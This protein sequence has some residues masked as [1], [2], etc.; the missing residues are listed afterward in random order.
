MESSSTVRSPAGRV[1]LKNDRRTLTLLWP[2]VVAFSLLVIVTSEA[3]RTGKP[4][5]RK[6]AVEE[7]DPTP[8]PTSLVISNSRIVDVQASPADYRDQA[9]PRWKGLK[10]L[11]QAGAVAIALSLLIFNLSQSRATSRATQQASSAAKRTAEATARQLELS[12]RP[13]ISIDTSIESPLTFTSEGAAQVSLKFVIRN[14]GSTPAKG[15]SVEPELS[16]ASQGERDPVIERSKVCEENRTREAGSDGTLFPKGEFT[17]SVTFLADAWD[18][19]KES[20]R[21]GSFSPV[22]IVCASYR[23]TFDDSARYNT[24]VIYY[25]RRIDPS[26][27]G[28]YLRMKD[29]VEVPRELLML[30]Y[31][32]IGAIA[33]N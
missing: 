17:K 27:P 9:A 31:D 10:G 30:E 6:S 25:L 14:V 2:L 13:W 5:R 32:P 28:A 20:N 23:S 21:T 22:V 3:N 16:I 8:Q 24:G 7:P 1:C 11:L 4:R 29:R 33:A 12:Q 26:H 15:L 19:V 18:I